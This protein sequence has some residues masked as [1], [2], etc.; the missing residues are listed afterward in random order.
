MVVINFLLGFTGLVDN[1]AHLGGL[2]AGFVVA[3]AL[4]KKLSGV[5]EPKDTTL[6]NAGVLLSLVYFAVTI[7]VLFAT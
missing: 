6:R 7:S 1:Y 4:P 3:M 5:S 2:I